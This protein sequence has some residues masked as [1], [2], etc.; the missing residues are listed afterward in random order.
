MSEKNENPNNK[1]SFFLGLFVGLSVVSLVSFFVLFAL[2]W[3][4]NNAD[5]DTS[6]SADEGQQQ[7]EESA[8][9]NEL[10]A[11]EIVSTPPTIT[12][13]DHVWGN[14][15]AKV[16]IV[17]YSEFECPYC[18]RH[19]PTMKQIKANYGDQVQ[20]VF[21]HFPLGFHANAKPAAKASECASDQGK[22]WE[23]YDKLFEAANVQRLGEE[24]LYTTLATELGL[25]LTVFN[26]C[27]AATTHDA[28]IQADMD[29]GTDLGVTGTPGTFVNDKLVSGAFPYD[30]FADI[31]DE[32]LAK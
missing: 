21:R 24:G 13:D 9:A 27:M 1:S 28:G 23:M 19:W 4:G 10:P 18:G 25:D 5:L 12:A 14:P 16:T 30:Y 6:V 3:Q 32:E 2:M 20:V 26:N 17:E 11:P 15:D 31:I 22:F 29:S 7:I 8:G